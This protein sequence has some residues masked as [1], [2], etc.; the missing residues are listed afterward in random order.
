MMP[1]GIQRRAPLTPLPMKGTSTITSSSSATTKIQGES[2][3]QIETGTCT[4]TSAGRDGDRHEHD[5]AR[6]EVGRRVAR[7]LR[8]VGQRDRGAVDHHQAEREQGDDDAD[9]G[10]V[11]AEQ[12]RRLAAL[13]ADPFAHRD[14]LGRAARLAAC[15]PPSAGAAAPRQSRARAALAPRLRRRPAQ[16][17][18]LMPS[19]L[20]APRRPARRP[21]ARTPRRGARSCGTCRGWRRPG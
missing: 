17:S 11:E 4:A 6:E 1:S 16:R 18:A 20:P 13:D 12:A 7:E 21:R 10:A 14:R 5:V 3:S 8:V 19:S 2:F 15:R 9:E